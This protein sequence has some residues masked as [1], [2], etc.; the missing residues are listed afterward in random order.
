MIEVRPSGSGWADVTFRLPSGSA[1]AGAAVA[2]EFNDWDRLAGQMTNGGGGW[3]VTVRVPAGRRYRFRYLV[4]GERWE[5]D[6]E[7]DDYV[8]NEFGGDDSVL[9]L[10]ADGPRRDRL[11]DPAAAG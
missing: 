9:D 1:T 7:A 11:G 8:P 3:A 5:N 4:D 6:W 10:T 2:G